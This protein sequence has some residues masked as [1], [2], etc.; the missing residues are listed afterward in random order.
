LARAGS[1]AGINSSIAIEETVAEVTPANIT[2]FVSDAD[3]VLT[4]PTTSR[5]AT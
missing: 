4:G 1:C 3:L 2:G 5:R